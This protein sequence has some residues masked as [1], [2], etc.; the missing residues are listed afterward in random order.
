MQKTFFKFL[1]YSKPVKKIEVDT[2]K[3]LVSDTK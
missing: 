1:S 2:E 3:I